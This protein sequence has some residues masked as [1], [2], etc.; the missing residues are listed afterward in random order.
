MAKV[1]KVIEE[2][3]YKRLVDSAAAASRPYTVPLSSSR[4]SSSS[5]SISLFSD[6]LKS[7]LNKDVVID[8]ISL[9]K[10]QILVQILELNKHL[11]LGTSLNEES[12]VFNP[13][14]GE[15]EILSTREVVLAL[16]DLMLNSNC[17]ST[18]TTTTTTTTTITAESSSQSRNHIRY[19]LL[20]CGINIETF[21]SPSSSPQTL[22]FQSGSGN[23]ADSIDGE[24][25]K[26][27]SQIQPLEGW[28]SFENVNPGL[29]I[30]L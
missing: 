22:P 19:L 8:D 11:D 7:V 17:A 25:S 3:T 13:H 24:E 10:L 12:K 21:F 18:T 15:W 27:T 23:I 26:T 16:H 29:K 4:S 28:I 20:I 30:R 14:K 9:K 5:S 2:S 1:Y 6:T